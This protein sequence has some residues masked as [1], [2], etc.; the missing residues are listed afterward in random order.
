MSGI[1]RITTISPLRML[2]LLEVHLRECGVPGVTL[3]RVKGYGKHPDFFTGDLLQDN[4][5]LVL[6]AGEDTVDRIVTTIADCARE[7]GVKAGILAVE[8]ID[9]LVRLT[10]GPQR[11]AAPSKPRSMR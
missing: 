4:T 5:R 3:E 8:S 6:Y 11:P 7:Y 9:R 2:V 1:K 10:D